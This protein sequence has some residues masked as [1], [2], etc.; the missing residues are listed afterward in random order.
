MDSFPFLLWT[1]FA[2]FAAAMMADHVL[3]IV[4]VEWQKEFMG[5]LVQAISENETQHLFSAIWDLMEQQKR[6]LSEP[7]LKPTL[8]DSKNV[9]RA[10]YVNEFVC[11][12]F[13]TLMEDILT[14]RLSVVVAAIRTCTQTNFACKFDPTE[15]ALWIEILPLIE[16]GGIIMYLGSMIPRNLGTTDAPASH[17]K[18]D[19][20]NVALKDSNSKI[21][22]EDSL[23]IPESMFLDTSGMSGSLDPFIDTSYFAGDNSHF[24]QALPEYYPEDVGVRDREYHVK[25]LQQKVNHVP[26][27]RADALNFDMYI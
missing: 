10:D 20:F 17:S 18:S 2:D 15:E 1:A 8:Q 19:L 9:I 21:P 25:L 27:T 7:L 23:L 12:L 13:L 14:P 24:L 22:S 3:K 5:K 6:T 11:G 4:G 16:A 26:V